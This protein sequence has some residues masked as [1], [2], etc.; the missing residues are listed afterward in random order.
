M[1]KLYIETKKSLLRV[2]EL[3]GQF[4]NVYKDDSAESAIKNKIDDLFREIKTS[5]D[6]LDIYVTKEP[7]IRKYDSKLKVDQVKYDFQ[8]YNTAYNSIK[9]RK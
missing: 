4:E 8:H 2:N 3:L 1:E 7:A 9:Y 5:F 6:Q